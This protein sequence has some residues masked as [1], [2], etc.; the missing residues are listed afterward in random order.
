MAHWHAVAPVFPEEVA[1]ATSSPVDL[2]GN[3]RL[4]RPPTIFR[5]SGVL[6]AEK[7]GSHYGCSSSNLALVNE[8]EADHLNEMD[9]A[10]PGRPRRKCDAARQALQIAN[11]A[12]WLARPS[13]LGFRLVVHLAEGEATSPSPNAFPDLCALPKYATS[14]LSA[15]DVA[16]A[17]QLNKALAPLSPRTTAFIAT[18]YLWLALH[19]DMLDVSFGILSIAI[20]ALLG[21]DDQPPPG[22]PPTKGPRNIGK[23]IRAR[24][25]ALVGGSGPEQALNYCRLDHWWTARNEVM[26]GDTLEARS[27]AEKFRLLGEAQELVRAVLRTIL[28]NATVT[29]EFSTFTTREAYLEKLAGT[30]VEPTATELAAVEAE[31]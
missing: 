21:P 18:R 3:V 6:I 5:S 25:A 30:F 11:V 28:L 17:R 13:P 26:H 31:P 2:G 29:V 1:A 19:E 14:R 22:T 15:L 8:Y 23:R 9:P 16:E 20:E 10:P 24:G 7:V 4:D 12:L 27:D